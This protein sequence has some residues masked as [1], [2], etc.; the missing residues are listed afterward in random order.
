MKKQC[1]K[2]SD[3]QGCGFGK[4]PVEMNDPVSCPHRTLG[5]KD[6]VVLRLSFWEWAV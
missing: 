2:R 5:P 6:Q 4:F 3:E 1:M